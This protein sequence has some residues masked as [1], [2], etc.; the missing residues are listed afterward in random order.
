MNADGLATT[1]PA[2]VKEGLGI[3]NQLRY[4]QHK[5]GGLLIPLFV[6]VTNQPL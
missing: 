5:K 4:F 3:F 1:T 2:E 6:V